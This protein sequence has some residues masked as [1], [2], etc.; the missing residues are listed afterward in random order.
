MS[1]NMVKLS[2]VLI[3]LAVVL[4]WTGVARAEILVQQW[5]PITFDGVDDQVVLPNVSI[6]AEGAVHLEFKA[7][8]LTTKQGLWYLTDGQGAAQTME[9]RIGISEEGQVRADLWTS[10]GS[11]SAGGPAANSY[12][13][14][15]NWH[16]F[17]LRWKKNTF[18]KITLDG[19]TDKTLDGV[20][21]FH[22]F[23]SSTGN[24]ALGIVNTATGPI[25]FFDGTLR[26]VQISNNYNELFVVPE[27]SIMTLTGSGLLGLLAYAWRRRE[28]IN[29]LFGS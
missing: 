24:H 19:I 25:R 14:D 12:L 21:L 9:Y 16:T 7:D 4:A 1:R 8:N 22:D 20:N 10:A 29:V 3:A 11:P 6:G 5:A 28:V 17:E 27:P 18:T 15:H 26:N 2:F 23:T 13:T